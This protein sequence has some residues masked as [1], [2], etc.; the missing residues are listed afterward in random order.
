VRGCA[1]VEYPDGVRWCADPTAAAWLSGAGHP[2]I[3]Q[4]ES[5]G[6]F[7]EEGFKATMDP[8]WEGGESSWIALPS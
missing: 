8:P 6:D 3:D 4:L 5:D 2:Y 7:A 1:H